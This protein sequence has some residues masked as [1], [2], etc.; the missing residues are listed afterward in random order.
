MPGTTSSKVPTTIFRFLG[1]DEQQAPKR[2]E[3]IG[4]EH[5]RSVLDVLALKAVKELSDGR[6][7][8]PALQKI[9]HLTDF[10]RAVDEEIE[11]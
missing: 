10:D 9:A 8:F 4:Q 5:R 3:Q 11:R 7:A 2:R 6:P 1:N